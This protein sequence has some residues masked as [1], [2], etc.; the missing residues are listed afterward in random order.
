MKITFKHSEIEVE[1]ISLKYNVATNYVQFDDMIK[2][3]IALV[4][5]S[6]TD[7]T[8]KIIDDLMVIK[9]LVKH[10]PALILY[11]DSVHLFF[12]SEHIAGKVLSDLK[13][14][15]FTF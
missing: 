2:R 12:A 3:F 10:N 9:T 6:Y 8:D 4:S 11:N 5:S 13:S 7:E 1:T 14:K 15:N